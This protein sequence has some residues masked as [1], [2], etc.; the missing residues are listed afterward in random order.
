MIPL[1]HGKGPLDFHPNVPAVDDLLTW[2][3]RERGFRGS[4]NECTWATTSFRQALSY[5]ENEDPAFVFEAVPEPG[6]ILSWARDTGDLIL[7]LEA[8]LREAAWNRDP[9]VSN[10][11]LLKDV[12]GDIGVF[13][14]YVARK[15]QRFV[16]EVALAYVADLDMV[17]ADWNDAESL[18]RLAGHK[19]EVWITGPCRLEPMTAPALAM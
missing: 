7:E 15:S 3:L 5:A 10:Q 12:Q 9:R 16:R 2:A 8:W 14:A 4:R 1:Y 11:G 13:D 19:G 18:A 17:E 6:A